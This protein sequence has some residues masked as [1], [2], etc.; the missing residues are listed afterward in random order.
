MILAID[1]GSTN[2]KVGLFDE[3][4]ERQ[5][6]RS[7]PVTYATRDASTVEFDS[8]QIWQQT[9]SLI[10][11]VCD[12]AGVAPAAIST[13]ALASQAQTFT[14]LGPDGRPVMPFM[15]W[16]DK[17]ALRESAALAEQLG[18]NFHSHCSFPIPMPQLQVSKLLWVRRHQPDW[19]TNDA[20]IVGLPGFLAWHLAGLRLTDVNLAA[21]SGLFSMKEQA[22]WREALEMCEIKPEQ[23]G[24]LVPTGQ[25][26]LA[27][28]TCSELN[29]PPHLRIVFAG[30][31]QTAGAYAM[32]S[33][34]IILTLGTA[35]VAYRRA[36]ESP[37]PFSS[38]GCWGPYPGGGFYE[39]A[40]RDEG[41]AAL[42]WAI[43]KLTSKDEA[44]FMK[45][46][47]SAAPGA[48]C[49]YPQLI[50]EDAAWIGSDDLG[51][52]ARAVLEGICFCARELIEKD[53]N[54]KLTGAPVVVTGGG[55]QNR[56]WAELLANILD[57]PLLRGESDVLLGA[58]MM[59]SPGHLPRSRDGGPVVSPDPKLAARYMQ[60]YLEWQDLKKSR[61][62]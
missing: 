49:F 11:Q 54:L 31:D 21:M 8:D 12:D 48:A 40:T 4:L 41:C 32:G 22:W 1:C 26:V 28:C 55:S 60:A 45:F 19:L 20:K 51:A 47:A 35:L 24:G 61:S 53:L 52:R 58:A 46:A 14:I 17:R 42:D 36:G 25:S 2:Y 50:F 15:S 29:L 3:K 5:A 56:F 33:A 62:F 34:N 38:G 30:N 57:R 13:I 59:A 27:R 23:L 6:V 43:E 44:A 18:K 16:M 37:G 10:R 39:L 9:L 7:S